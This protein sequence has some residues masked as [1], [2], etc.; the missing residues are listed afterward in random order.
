[1]KI[2]IIGGGIIGLLTARELARAGQHVTVVD[3]SDMGTES[4]WAGG[5][6]LSPLYPWRYSTAVNALAKWGQQYYPTLAQELQDEG[7]VDPQWIQSGLLVL[8]PNEGPAAIQWARDYGTSIDLLDTSA[9]RL[10]EPQL[11]FNAEQSIWLP[12]IAHIRNPRLLKCLFQGCR[13][14][15]VKLIP[16]QEVSQLRQDGDRITAVVTGSEALPADRVIVA[17]GAWSARVLQSLEVAV[18]IRPVR[19]QMLMYRGE[20][21]LIR[22]IVLLGGHYV[23]PRQDGR[24]LVGSTLEEV[25]F[26]NSTTG[27]AESEL[28]AFATRQFPCLE[29]LPIERHWSGLRP[30][31]PEG[32]PY[33]CPI[34]GYTGLY[35]NSGHFR[36]GVILG[37]ASARLMADLVLDREPIVDPAPYELAR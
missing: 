4:S 20:P 12:E 8:D 10:Q 27:D 23:I 2:V 26:D 13:Q 19:G 25:G 36:N 7:G 30:G 1:M 17:S 29:S 34:P 32:I 16:Q 21:G 14:L 5:G 28:R 9:T 6:I 18:A 22:H 35:L 37:P 11:V 31:S 24:I 33:I 15:G 3:K